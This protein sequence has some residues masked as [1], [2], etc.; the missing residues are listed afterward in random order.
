[1]P[2]NMT[3]VTIPKPLQRRL[4][5]LA[6]SEGKSQPGLIEAM[7]KTREDQAFWAQLSTVTP[8]SYHAALRD[9]DDRLAE[10]YSVENEPIAAEEAGATW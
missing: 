7:V 4:A 3:S 5:N 9:D 8:A 10:D 2:E 1:M 6:K